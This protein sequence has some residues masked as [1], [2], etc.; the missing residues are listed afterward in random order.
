MPS[1]VNISTKRTC[2]KC[3]FAAHYAREDLC[4]MGDV[5]PSR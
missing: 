2:K 5:H 3:F 1:V 4:V